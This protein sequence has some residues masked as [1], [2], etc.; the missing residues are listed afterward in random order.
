[1]LPLVFLVAIT[2]SVPSLNIEANCRTNTNEP[3]AQ[4]ATEYKRC[5][6]TERSTLAELTKNWGQYPAK[7]RNE[8]AHAIRVAP[9][10]SYV[11]L[12]TCIDIQ[13]DHPNIDPVPTK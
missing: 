9:E 8:C 1:M 4:A 12:L 13:K 5:V 3:A 10:A 7:T 2:S 6:D 11:E